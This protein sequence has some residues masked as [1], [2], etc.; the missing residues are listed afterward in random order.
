MPKTRQLKWYWTRF[1]PCLC[2]RKTRVFPT[3]RMPAGRRQTRCGKRRQTRA[4][5]SRG[6]TWRSKGQARMGCWMGQS[7]EEKSYKVLPTAFSSAASVVSLY[8][9]EKDSRYIRAFGDARGRHA[10]DIRGRA[11]SL[12]P[13]NRQRVLQRAPWATRLQRRRA[14]RGRRPR[15]CR[16]AARR[17]ILPRGPT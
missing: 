10:T 11:D 6:R 2:P 17:P 16:Q 13:I 14:Q 3:P 8:I 5:E 4:A 15:R 9:L 12:A 7:R 1:Y